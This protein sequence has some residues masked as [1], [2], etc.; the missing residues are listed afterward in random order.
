MARKQKPAPEK[1]KQ[2]PVSLTPH[3]RRELEAAAAKSSVSLGE[4]VRRRL[5]QSFADETVDVR[6][7][8]LADAVISLALDV[9]RETGSSWHQHPAANRALRFAITARLARLKPEGDPSFKAGELPAN[10]IITSSDDPEAIGQTIE[11]FDFKS[12]SNER[13]KLENERTRQAILARNPMLRK[14]HEHE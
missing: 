6:T 4:E 9:E 3:L 11:A 13:L 12:R 5:F 14:D 10:R 8:D 1:P 7:R 2:L